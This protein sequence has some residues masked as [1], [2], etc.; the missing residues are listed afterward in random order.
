MGETLERWEGWAK[1]FFSKEHNIMKPK[2]DHIADD[3]WG[4]S[5]TRAPGNLH[6]IR[7]QAELTQITREEPGIET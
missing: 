4:K 7:K 2:I 6:E 3:E 1:E 5:I